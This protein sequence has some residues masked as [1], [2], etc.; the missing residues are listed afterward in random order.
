M[1]L[2]RWAEDRIDQLC[3]TIAQARHDKD[4]EELDAAQQRSVLDDAKQLWT[5]AQQE[6]AERRVQMQHDQEADQVIRD[7]RYEISH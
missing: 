4:Y 5:E 2:A 3:N 1:S 6:A 7:H